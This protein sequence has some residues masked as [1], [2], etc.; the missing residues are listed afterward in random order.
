MSFFDGKVAFVTGGASGIGLS[1]AQKLLECNI[2][3]VGIVDLSDDAEKMVLKKLNK[4]H[5]DKVIVIKADVSSQQEL[6]GAFEKTVQ[7][8]NNLDIVFNNAG[9]VKERKNWEK[10]IS[11]N[12]EAVIRGTYLARDKYFPKYKSGN[13]GVVINTASIL[14]LIAVDILPVY[15]ATKHGLIGFGKSLGLEK[16]TGE[17]KVI[18]I[19]PGPVTTPFLQGATVILEQ[20]KHLWEKENTPEFVA[21]SVTKIIQHAQHGSVWM[22]ENLEPPYEVGFPSKS[23]L[24]KTSSNI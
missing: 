8:F 24:R 18:T 11:T 21:E 1:I 9:I 16:N 15:C 3:G 2:K 14:G 6:E 4:I 20:T 5:H 13:E 19:C 10:A 12:L 23:K 7:K 22:I 17:F